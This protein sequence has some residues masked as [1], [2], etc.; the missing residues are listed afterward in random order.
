MTGSA[1]SCLARKVKIQTDNRISA[2]EGG[3]R[4]MPRVLTLSELC[5]KLAELWLLQL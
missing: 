2:D 1:S 3:G 5:P 4:K